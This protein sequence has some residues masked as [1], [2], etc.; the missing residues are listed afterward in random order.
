MHVRNMILYLGIFFL[1][2]VAFMWATYDPDLA[3]G[4]PSE[5]MEAYNRYNTL[6]QQGRYSEAEPYAKEALRLGNE[7]LGRNDP[8]VVVLL[9]NLANL[10]RAQG[11]YAEAEPLYKRSLEIKKKALGPEHPDVAESLEV[12]AALLRQ[13]AR[14]GQAESMETPAK[15]I[16]AAYQELAASDIVKMITTYHENELIFKSDYLGKTLI[17][18]MYFN[19]V[20]GA[21]F[22]GG[23]F[24]RFD[25]ING[26]AGLTCRFPKTL[27]NEIVDWGTGKSVYLTGVVYEVVLFT[28]Y[29]KRCRFK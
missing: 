18:T 29:L 1:L 28:L 10:H 25:G 3:S 2:A 27:P 22:G 21:A 12:Y 17:A 24:V 7:E 14:A 15:A 5:L 19:A 13:I 23:H 20:R 9:D 26:S 11:R 4:E 8:A 16:R 6:Y